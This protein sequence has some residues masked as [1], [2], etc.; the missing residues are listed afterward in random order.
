MLLK[1]TL[2]KLFLDLGKKLPSKLKNFIW[3]CIAGLRLK[4]L[5]W[6]LKGNQVELYRQLGFQ[7]CKKLFGI[8][9]SY[10]KKILKETDHNVRTALYNELYE[11]IYNF[12]KQQIPGGKEFGFSPDLINEFKCLFRNKTVIDYGCGKGGSTRLIS[13]Y[14]KFVYGI[15][16]SDFAVRFAQAKSKN[17]QNVEYRQNSDIFVPFENETIETVYSKDLLEH[18]HPA[19]AILHLKEIYRVLEHGGKYLFWTPGSKSG[20]HDITQCFY[21]PRLGFKPKADHIKE[22]TFADLIEIMQ[23]IGFRKIELPDL[24][25]EV[26]MVVTK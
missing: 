20:P 14:A 8:S 15:D 19:D 18:L 25:R 26:L 12:I 17:L 3:I 9:S 1:D 22:Y 23:E 4:A 2:I 24:T 5:F 11:K 16:A 6:S 7:N 10:H 21:P 13:K